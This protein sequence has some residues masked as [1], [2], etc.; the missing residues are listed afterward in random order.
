MGDMV[1][2]VRRQSGQ[3]LDAWE[4]PCN[5]AYG[6]DLQS[7]DVFDGRASLMLSCYSWGGAAPVAAP[8]AT[9]PDPPCAGW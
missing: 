2:A 3:M 9:G 8:P 5:G 7:F 6:A 4:T 1:V